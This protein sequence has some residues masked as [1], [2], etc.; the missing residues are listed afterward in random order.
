M[1]HRGLQP[2]FAWLAVAVG[3]GIGRLAVAS[4][5]GSQSG[6]LVWQSLP[7]DRPLGGHTALVDGA[8]PAMILY[9]GER[10]GM[11]PPLAMRQFD[12]SAERD[13]WSDFRTTG[14]GPVPRLE[15]RGLPGSA[16]VLDPQE[17]L[18]LVVCDCRNGSTHLLDLANRRWSRAP[19]DR[20]LPLW[21]PLLAY[22]PANDRAILYGGDEQGDA[23]VSNAGW[24]YDLTPARRGWRALPDAPFRLVYQAAGIDDRTGHLVAFGGQDDRGAA[25]ADLWRLDLRRAE[26][27]G[28]W[29][30]LV[31]LGPTP[32]AR[33]GAS[34]T[35]FPGTS[36]A[37]LIGGW[38][39]EGD[40]GDLWLLDYEDPANPRWFSLGDRGPAGARSG[41]STAWDPV[42]G[43]LVLYGGVRG[44]DFLA[45]TWAVQWLPPGTPSPTAGT[46]VPA[47]TAT[48]TELAT[49][50]PTV[51]PTGEPT[52]SATAPPPER[53]IYL[54]RGERS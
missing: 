35:F 49:T 2:K 33:Y 27:P 46:L 39:P 23:V 31:P 18:A 45:D 41:H 4:Q 40:Y 20:A 25:V 1:H 54:P 28:A 53:P 16:A 24:A 47:E 29:Q 12:L 19:N 17:R 26:Q 50:S 38:S 36:K 15:G 21:Y 37:V 48:P 10:D 34:L 32:A 44:Y 14:S 7:A 8:P 43:R 13:G 51:S 11:Q 3:L 52:Q 22:D 6:S 9:G 30:R 42:G 5:V